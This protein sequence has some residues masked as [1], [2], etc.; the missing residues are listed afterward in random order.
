MNVTRFSLLV[1]CLMLCTVSSAAERAQFA[2]STRPPQAETLA[3][4]KLLLSFQGK[5]SSL[6]WDAGVVKRAYETV[7]AL[8]DNQVIVTGNSSGSVLAVYFS[9]FGFTQTS[10]EYA[11]YRIQHADTR[12]IRGNENAAKKAGELLLDKPTEISP[13]NL[14]EYVAFALGVSD[15]RSARDI[16]EVVRRSRVRPH[17]PLMIV[18]AN[19]EVLDNRAPGNALS[20]KDLKQFDPTNFS[21]SW[22]PDVYD[23]YRSRP[24]Q[25]TRENPNLRLGA[26]PYIGKACTC[27]VDQSMFDLLKRIPD[28]ERLCDLRLVKTPADLALAIQAS[29]AEPSYFPP[30]PEMDY[31]KLYVGDK[32]GQAG[33]TRRRSYVGGFIMSLTAQDARRMLPS[34]RVMGT[35]VA[36]VPLPARELLKSWYLVDLQQTADLSAWWADMEISIPREVQQAIVNRD[37]SAQQEFQ[38]GYDR[39]TVCF[40]QDQGL[41][42]YVVP[43]QYRQPAQAALNNPQGASIV[44]VG[45]SAGAQNLPTMRGLG[46]L[47]GGQ[48]VAAVK[49][50]K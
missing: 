21:V 25:F 18:A 47:L 14:K 39:A 11:A 31:Q 48:K 19:K 20:S 50:G 37:F 44:A 43:P 8:A 9:C 45:Y 41:P 32:L 33:N 5:G 17:Y 22:K 7:P 28:A 38:A 40:N 34:L 13:E 36:R 12:A 15:W 3:D 46:S 16:A 24:A 35:G 49:Q 2:S 27:F 30:V 23:F 1:A 4:K 6:A 42:Q 10:V 26:S 29:V